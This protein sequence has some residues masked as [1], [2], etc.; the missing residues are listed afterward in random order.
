MRCNIFPF[1]PA[2]A[3]THMF[4]DGC[5]H[6]QCSYTK[7]CSHTHAQHTDTYPFPVQVNVLRTH[8]K[9]DMETIFGELFPCERVCLFVNKSDTAFECIC[10]IL[11]AAVIN[12]YH[13][14]NRLN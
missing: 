4:N 10:A 1:S 3:T 13:H 14:E 2:K 11:M 6:S 9:M 5:T 7:H 12:K 8:A